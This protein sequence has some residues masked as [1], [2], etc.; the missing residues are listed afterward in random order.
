MA[1]IQNDN[2]HDPRMASLAQ[3]RDAP[4]FMGRL[5]SIS[6]VLKENGTACPEVGVLEMSSAHLGEYEWYFF[7]PLRKLLLPELGKIT[8]GLTSFHSRPGMEITSVEGA[9][10]NCAVSSHKGTFLQKHS[11]RSTSLAS[12]DSK[13]SSISHKATLG[14][15]APKQGRRQEDI[16]L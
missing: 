3:P 4:S 10:E 16:M 11:D 8:S 6:S 12:V 13:R 5:F 15:T 1:H 2:S 14:L 7:P 9:S